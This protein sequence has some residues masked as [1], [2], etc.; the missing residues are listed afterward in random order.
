MKEKFS[1][2]ESTGFINKEGEFLFEVKEAELTTSKSGKPM[3]KFS[4]ESEEAGK[5]TIYHSL[6]KNAR[7]SYNNLIKA[8]LNLDTPEK[9][10]AFEC[11]YETIHR[12]LIG[13]CFYGTVEAQSYMKQTKVPTDDGVFDT[14]E[15]EATSY[16]ITSYAPA[17]LD[18]DNP[19]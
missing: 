3:V 1:D 5:A 7:W 19:F 8:C 15:K 14:I 6:E 4:V 2:Y 13:K 11:D 10:R 9:I 18:E 17:G 12:D 16:K